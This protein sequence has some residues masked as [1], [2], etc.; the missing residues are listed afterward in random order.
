MFSRTIVVVGATD[1]LRVIIELSDEFIASLRSLSS[2]EG[3]ICSTSISAVGLLLIRAMPII[4]SHIQIMQLILNIVGAFNASG[5]DGSKIIPPSTYKVGSTL[6]GLTIAYE[7][8]PNT[9]APNPCP[10][11]MIPLTVPLLLG[12]YSHA[13]RTGIK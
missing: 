5:N 6:L 9:N 2:S 10:P 1:S 7:M 8:N 4:A 12:K 3:L 11:T 13:I